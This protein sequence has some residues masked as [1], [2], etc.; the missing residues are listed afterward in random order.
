MRK[1]WISLL[2]FFMLAGM[3]FKCR[4]Q[5][6]HDTELYAR[7][8]CLMDAD[9]GRVL[10]SKE[11]EQHMPMASTTKIMTCILALEM[12]HPDEVVTVSAN[13]AAQPKVHMGAEQGEQFLLQD[14]LYALMLN[15]DNDAAVMIAEHLSGSTEAFIEKM[16]LKAREIGCTNTYFITPNGLDAEDSYGVH[17]T[18][19]VDLALIMRYC[20]MES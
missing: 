1:V 10:Y 14:L 15:S 17:S 2:L 7:A 16:N 5:E 11:G 3:P 12:G 13:A 20:I 18:T 4:A 6:I 19:A 8:A 9:T